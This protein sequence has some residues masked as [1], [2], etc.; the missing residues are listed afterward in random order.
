MNDAAVQQLFDKQAISEVIYNY[1]RGLDRMDRDLA[2]TIWHEGGT[3]DYGAYMFQGTG[4]G[5][6]DWV[7]LQHAGMDRHSHQISNILIEVDGD[8]A[9]SESYVTARR[10][11]P[12]HRHPG[13]L[14]RP[15][16]TP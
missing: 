6:I 8:G 15:L 16:V 4:A 12:R 1:C 3:A 7:W 11:E 5:F 13:S 14:R 10:P 2:S 9:V